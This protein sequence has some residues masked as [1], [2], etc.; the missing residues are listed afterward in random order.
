MKKFVKPLVIAICAVLLVAGSV[1]G[2][3]AYLTAT[4][5]EVTNTFT[6]GNITIALDEAQ[7]NEYGEEVASAARVKENSYK[8]VPGRTYK[9]DPTIHVTKGSEA[10]YLFV[11]IES[12]ISAV[13]MDSVADQLTANGWKPLTGNVYYYDDVVDASGEEADV[14]VAVFESFTVNADATN[15]Q[16]AAC[17]DKTIKVTAYAV[18][19][20]GFNN[21]T[22]A[23]SAGAFGN[24]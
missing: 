16:I 11:K 3:L 21:A 23:W 10:C 9:K 1:A 19:S 4:D 2:T 6:V 7:V 13:V 18:Q 14:N 8:L 17:N 22:A 24:P 20:H 15:E 12:N 5:E